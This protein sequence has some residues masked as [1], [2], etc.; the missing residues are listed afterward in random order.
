MA[1]LND[2][3]ARGFR[4]ALSSFATGVTIVTATDHEGQSVGMTASSFN[5]VSTEPPLVL[6]SVTKTARSAPAF[7]KAEYFSIHVLASDQTDLSNK[8]AKSGADKFAHTVFSMNE[9][10]VPILEG[11]AARF[12]CKTWSVY[13][14]GDHWIIV[15]EVKSIDTETKEGL[16]FGGGS[17]AI[18]APLTTLSKSDAVDHDAEGLVEDMFFY[19]LSRAYHRMSNEFHDAVRDSGLTVAQWR[20]LASL[21]GQSTLALSTLAEQTFLDPKSLE[22][23]LGFLQE[24]GLCVVSGEADSRIARGTKSGHERV[25]HLF[26]LARE[27][28][29]AALEGSSSEQKNATRDTLKRISIAQ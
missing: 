18:A 7:K 28:E 23:I 1:K 15:G 8:F 10:N 11:C 17:Y 5:S 27:Q 25:V 4:D 9:N 3:D 2:F 26:D 13:E 19:H 14:G 22:D 24:D 20:I 12:D 16:V 29:S 21:H 6:W